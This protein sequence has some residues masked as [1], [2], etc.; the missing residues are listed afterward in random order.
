VKAPSGCCITVIIQARRERGLDPPLQTIRKKRRN[1]QSGK[2]CQRKRKEQKKK[3]LYNRE[4]KI[5][6]QLKN[7]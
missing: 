6:L 2:W 4:N 7:E 3:Y 1:K 5:I